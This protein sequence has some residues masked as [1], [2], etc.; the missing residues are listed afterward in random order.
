MQVFV[1]DLRS[2]RTLARLARRPTAVSRS[3]Y[4]PTLSADGRLVA[5]ES[6]DGPA[7]R[8][9]CASTC[10]TCAA[11]A[12]SRAPRAASPATSPSRRLSADGRRLAFTALAGRGHA[13]G[14]LRPR[15]AQ[16]AH[17]GRSRPAGDEACEPG[18]PPTGRVVAYTLRGQAARRTSCVHDLHAGRR[19]ASRAPDGLGG[20]RPS[21]R[22][23]PTGAASRSSRGRAG[24]PTQVVFVRDLRRGATHARLARRRPRRARRPT[25]SAAHP[26]I[27][28]DG[29]R[30]AFTSDAW[31]LS[32]AKCNS[33]RGIFVRDLAT[34]DDDAGQRGDGA[35]RY[36]GPT[37]GSSSRA[38]TFVTFLCA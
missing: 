20:S 13:L 34:H 10:A 6:S 36:L 5:Y 35:N 7:S 17:V 3:A 37:K 14:G 28:G 33:A 18:S 12:A 23:R 38:D 11:A 25:G 19:A 32:P 9:G 27:S 15:P 16:R 26:A 24:A 29:R 2:G 4:N 22:C 21:R 30:V 8:G 31:N 1:R